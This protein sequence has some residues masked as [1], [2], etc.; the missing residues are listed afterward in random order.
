MRVV[1]TFADL[2]DHQPV[3]AAA[4]NIDWMVDNVVI[5]YLANEQVEITLT[6]WVVRR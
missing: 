1:C 6:K 4:G 2:G 3:H 5:H